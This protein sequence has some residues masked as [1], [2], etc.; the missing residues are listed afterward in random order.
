M[1]FCVWLMWLASVY[2]DK[3]TNVDRNRA[4]VDKNNEYYK[5]DDTHHV[6]HPGGTAQHAHKKYGY[7]C[8]S[9]VTCQCFC[10]QKLK[11]W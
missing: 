9:H 3:N 5:N 8:L 11:C 10:W 6:V 7:L 4:D 2:V 1:S